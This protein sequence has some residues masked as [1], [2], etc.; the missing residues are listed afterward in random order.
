[1]GDSPFAGDET[2]SHRRLSHRTL[3]HIHFHIRL[4][5][6]TRTFLL[7]DSV[8]HESLHVFHTHNGENK[9][10][11]LAQRFLEHELIHKNV[12]P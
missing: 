10:S 12:D 9:T 5:S 7:T 2:F 3:S 11:F 8:T 1:M 4:V 6:C